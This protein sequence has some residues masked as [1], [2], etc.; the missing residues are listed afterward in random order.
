AVRKQFELLRARRVQLRRQFDGD[1]IDLDAVIDARADFRA[2]LPLSQA[3]YQITRP[4]R[5]D[6]AVMLLV[7][8]SGS[9]DGWISRHRRVIDVEREALLLVCHALEGLGSPYAVQ[10]FS[11][12]GPQAVTVRAVKRF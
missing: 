2:G 5:R 7:D 4:A 10:A 11:G 6:L 9:T 8:I 12:N 1:D 3:L